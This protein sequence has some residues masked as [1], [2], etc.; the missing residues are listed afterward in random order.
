[1]I[2]TARIKLPRPWRRT[3]VLGDIGF[4]RG[5]ASALVLSLMRTAIC[6]CA[7]SAAIS[8]ERI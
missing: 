6:E 5:V 3:F 7:H 8:M 1:M 2:E 4:W